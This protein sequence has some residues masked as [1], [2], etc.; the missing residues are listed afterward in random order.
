MQAMVATDTD[1]IDARLTS[2]ERLNWLLGE[3]T[4]ATVLDPC[5]GLGL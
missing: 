3:P 1:E 5:P 4:V 2:A